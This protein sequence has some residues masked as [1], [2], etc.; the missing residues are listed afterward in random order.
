MSERIT[1]PRIFQLKQDRTKIVCATAYDALEASLLDE[2][3]VDLILVG[4]SVASVKLGLANTVFATLE[5]MVHHTAAAARGVERALVVGDLPFGSYQSSVSQC[6]D[7]A[8]KLMQAGARAVKLEGDFPD[9]VAALTHA[10]IP[11]MG[12]LGMTPQSVNKFGGHRVQAKD[13]DGAASLLASALEL[14]QAGAF[15]IVLELVPSEVA[16]SVTE[17][18]S[19]PTIGIGA[20]PYCSGEVQVWSDLLGLGTRTYKHAKP[21]LS[22]RELILGALRQYAAEVREGKFP[23][24]DNSF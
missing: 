1:A 24:E 4:D 3:G 19:I 2:A 17:A 15:A 22:G 5:M 10:G 21:Y 12:H 18:L 9:R 23:S 11:T 14:Q 20:G 6:V 8:S 7:S 16:R 13:A